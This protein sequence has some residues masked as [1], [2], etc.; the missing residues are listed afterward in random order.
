M[1]RNSKNAKQLAAARERSKSRL[2][3]NPGP[4]ATT[5]KHGKQ[6]A[7]WQLGTYKEF[8]KGKAKKSR[9]PEADSA[10]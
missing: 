5:P 8:I 2:A 3:G 10:I 6:R 7:W 1:S 9:M 4:K